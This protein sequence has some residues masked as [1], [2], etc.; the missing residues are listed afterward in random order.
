MK[1][2]IRLTREEKEI[3]ASPINGEFINIEPDEF[4]EIAK[5]IKAR[6]KN[7]VLNIRINSEDLEQIKRKADKLGVKYQ[8]FISELL[9][10]VAHS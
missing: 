7:S 8:S 2:N 6:Q 9:H 5:S 4:K 10:R 1:K 3:E